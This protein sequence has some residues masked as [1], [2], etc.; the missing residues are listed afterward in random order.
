M[1]ELEALTRNRYFYGKLLS[2]EN[3]ELEQRYFNRKRWL[4]NRLA[5]GAGV[6]RG[7][8]VVATMDASRVRVTVG[9]AI[10]GCGRE[11]IVPSESQPVDPRALTDDRGLATGPRVDGA[12][13]VTLWLA[14]HECETA[15][16]RLL[17]T[18]C[19]APTRCVWGAIAERYAV[20]VRQGA[21][22]AA[23]A[24]VFDLATLGQPGAD[25]AR[26]VATAVTKAPLDPPADPAVLL[27]EVTLAAAGGPPSIDITRRA[28]VYGNLLLREL[29]PALTPP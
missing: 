14:Y 4:L 26:V 13:T 2:T 27:A 18:D 3:L 16:E 10:D 23:T 17:V 12:G 21:A 6:L 11:I 24:P 15:P 28:V 20:L 25:A 8:D 29:L 22:P 7:L 19:E 5:L 1:L 9:V